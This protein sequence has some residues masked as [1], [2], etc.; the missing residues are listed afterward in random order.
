MANF[1]FDRLHF[2]N[3]TKPFYEKKQKQKRETSVE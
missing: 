2:V 1:E 3:F